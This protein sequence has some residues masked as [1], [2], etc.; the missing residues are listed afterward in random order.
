MKSK[1]ALYE[2]KEFKNLKEL[3]KDAIQKYSSHYILI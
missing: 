1:N 3:M 2:A